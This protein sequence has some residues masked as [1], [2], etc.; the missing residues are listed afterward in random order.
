MVCIKF[1]ESQGIDVIF[2]WLNNMMYR[3]NLCILIIHS[4]IYYGHINLTC[5]FNLVFLIVHNLYVQ[6]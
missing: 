1:V 3:Q 6:S 2:N 5:W 4:S